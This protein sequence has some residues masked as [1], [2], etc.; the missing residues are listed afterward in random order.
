[1][2]VPELMSEEDRYLFVLEND[3]VR[4]VNV[5]ESAEYWRK[6]LKK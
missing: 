3:S 6:R 4:P 5:E 2:R 1:V